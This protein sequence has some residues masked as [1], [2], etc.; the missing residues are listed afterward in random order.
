MRAKSQDQRR[1]SQRRL[2]LAWRIGVGPAARP[3]RPVV[4]RSWGTHDH[5]IDAIAPKSPAQGQAEIA[6]N[7]DIRKFQQT[8]TGCLSSVRLLCGP[9]LGRP[10]DYSVITPALRRISVPAPVA[11]HSAPSSHRAGMGRLPHLHGTGGAHR[12]VLSMNSTQAS[13]HGRSRY[14][15]IRRALCCRSTTT[16]S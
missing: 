4:P 11:A 8:G 16:S 5:G 10:Q 2:A 12:G 7:I 1:C 15:S 14:P 3:G 6:E 13:S 9:R